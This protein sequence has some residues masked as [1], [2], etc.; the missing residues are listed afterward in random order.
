M[1]DKTKGLNDLY[2][3]TRQFFPPLQGFD[4]HSVFSICQWKGK[5][6]TVYMRVEIIL[7]V[8]FSYGS[9]FCQRESI[10]A[11]PGIDIVYKHPR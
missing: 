1:G 2:N 8:N 4:F 9:L 3:G 10:K 11:D 6:R 5:L 7:N